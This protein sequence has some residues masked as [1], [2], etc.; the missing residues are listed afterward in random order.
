MGRW[1]S[2]DFARLFLF[3]YVENSGCY[4]NKNMANFTHKL[5]PVLM[6]KVI[7]IFL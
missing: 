3:S 5:N 7:E 2:G 4:G 6:Q 1:H